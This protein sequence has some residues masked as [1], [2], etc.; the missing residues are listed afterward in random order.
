VSTPELMALLDDTPRLSELN[1]DEFDAIVVCGG[2]SPMFTFPGRE[3]LSKAILAFYDAEK[4]TA[5]LCHGT[6]ALLDIKTPDGRYLI[7]GK[8]ITGFSN[9]EEDYSDQAVGQKVMPFRIQDDAVARGAN[10]AVGGLFRS[11]VVRDGNLITGQ[12]QYSGAKVAA[13]VI[14]SLGV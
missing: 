12:Q 13:E 1:L 2:F 5:I 3:D 4:P 8:T 9:I 11:F 14:A 7:E 6:C 10:F